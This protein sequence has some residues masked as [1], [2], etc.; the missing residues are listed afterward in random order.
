MTL[1][2][3]IAERHSVRAYIDKPVAEEAAAALR[4]KIAAVNE[5]AGLHVQLVLNEPKA[6]Q[7]RLA[8]YG[9]FRNCSNYIVMAGKPSDCFEENVGYY[10]EQI[11]LLAQT[12]GL[13][14]CW[15]GLTYQKVSGAFTLEEGEKIACVI[16]LG[17][18]ETSGVQHKSRAMDEI[19]NVSDLHPAWFKAGIEAVL[20]AP[21]A[22]NQQK[23]RFEM[24]NDLKTIVALPGRSLVGYLK[25][26]LGIA[27]C[28]F[29]IAVQEYEKTSGKK[30]DYRWSR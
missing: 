8:R 9:K 30:A 24:K 5:E 7:S 26:D 6:F 3:A 27:K 22:V 2:E 16:A 14:S 29:D 23:F 28:H 17:Y 10:G 11:V 13:N 25:I 15:V 20:L 12:L 19:S 1:Y 18:G 4:D 21:T